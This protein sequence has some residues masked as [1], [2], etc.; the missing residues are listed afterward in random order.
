[1]KKSAESI[2]SSQGSNQSSSANLRSLNVCRTPTSTSACF[3]S[4]QLTKSIAS[5]VLNSDINIDM[6]LSPV[7]PI[8][9]LGSLN[10]SNTRILIPGNN[11]SNRSMHNSYHHGGL[12]LSGSSIQ[13]HSHNHSSTHHHHMNQHFQ[14]GSTSLISNHEAMRRGRY[15]CPVCFKAFSEK[16]NMKRHT[17]IHL[18]QRHRYQCDLCSKGF[19]WKD[20]FNRHRRSHHL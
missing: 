16:G 18:P 20:N 9:M 12:T 3:N 2:S 4:G 8:A 1:M 7:Q 5:S 17:L 13:T 15:S 10:H 19:S 11:P 14:S 6:I